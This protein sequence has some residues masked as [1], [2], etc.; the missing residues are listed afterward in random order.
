MG[1]GVVAWLKQTGLLESILSINREMKDVSIQ[2]LTGDICHSCEQ[3]R[4]PQC[5]ENKKFHHDPIGHILMKECVNHSAFQA[6][7]TQIDA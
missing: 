6:W 4:R 2:L 5:R 7:F 3:H 1:C